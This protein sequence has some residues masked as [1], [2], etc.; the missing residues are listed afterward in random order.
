MKNVEQLDQVV[1]R[2]VTRQPDG[3]LTVEGGVAEG[4]PRVVVHDARLGEAAAGG[5][6][7]EAFDA[8]I[9]GNDAW[10]VR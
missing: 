2:A 6:D 4:D 9:R 3:T 8:L 5:G 10:T 1:I 7:D